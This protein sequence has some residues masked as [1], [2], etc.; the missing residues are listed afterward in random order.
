[1]TEATILSTL[2]EMLNDLKEDADNPNSA[3]LFK[4]VIEN[5]API[6][7]SVE[8]TPSVCYYMSHTTY[9]SYDGLRYNCKS[10]L[11]IYI[12]AKHRTRGLS[13]PDILSPL[14]QRVK[15]AVQSM[16]S[17][18]GS[19]TDAFIAKTSRDGGTVLPYTIAEL[20]LNVDF[21]ELKTCKN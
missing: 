17:Y 11:A 13:I 9:D 7:T 15:E 5:N 1:M 3:P 14:I 19:I 20:T 16:P 6:W 2:D 4:K 18:S 21:I 12:Y 8:V 10:N